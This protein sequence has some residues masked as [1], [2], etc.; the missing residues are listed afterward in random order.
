MKIYVVFGYCGEYSYHIRWTVRAFKTEKAAQDF[1]LEAK[2]Q[3]DEIYKEWAV[4]NKETHCEKYP[5]NDD[6]VKT[7]YDSR[8]CFDYTGTDYDYESVELED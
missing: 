1:A 5:S 8:P 2:K 7:K 3:I 6:E 4:K